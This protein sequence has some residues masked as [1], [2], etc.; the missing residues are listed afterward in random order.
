MTKKLASSSEIDISSKL[1]ILPTKDILISCNYEKRSKL[2]KNSKVCFNLL[3]VH[4]L[5]SILEKKLYFSKNKNCAVTLMGI[6]Q[7][8][9]TFY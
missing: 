2:K 8:K 3:S 6:F 5:N 7:S 9:T 4:A 1:K